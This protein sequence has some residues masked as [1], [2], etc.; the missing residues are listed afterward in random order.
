MLTSSDASRSQSVEPSSARQCD[1]S[2]VVGSVNS[3]RSIARCVASL[4]AACDGID[5]EVIVVD[6][7]RDGTLDRIGDAR[8][9]VRRMPP[10]TLTPRLWSKG[11]LSARGR[12][13]AFTTGHLAVG[14][15]WARALLREIA[16][17][18][19]GAGGPLAL[20]PTSGPVDWAVFYLRYSA[21]LE[22]GRDVDNL[23][24]IPGDNAAYSGDLLRAHVDT[25]ADGFW[26]VDFHRRLRGH[27]PAAR[28]AF[29]SDA[30]AEFGPSDSLMNFAR[31][32]FAHGQHFGAW[33]VTVANRAALLVVA[34]MPLVPLV[35]L[36]RIARRVLRHPS[37]RRR[38]VGA[39]PALAV[40]SAAWAVGE[41]WGALRASVTPPTRSR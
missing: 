29:V 32:R 36:V 28:L 19:A 4:E 23:P 20:A 21:F 30:V 27:D 39:L 41:A 10:G 35:L 31:Q 33:R 9:T 40:L 38:F 11:Y 1:L 16:G 2:I 7:S 15:E 25:F 14:S 3:A 26:E 8:V 13:V 12:V 6:A 34:A 5:A 22:T 18:A 24:E 17:G 37:H